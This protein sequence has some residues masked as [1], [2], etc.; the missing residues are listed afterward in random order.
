MTWTKVILAVALLAASASSSPL[1]HDK[2]GHFGSD[3]RV[4][5]DYRLPNNTAPISYVVRLTPYI[6]TGNFTF[7]GE[8]QILL[9][10][11]EPTSTIT[12]HTNQLT[13]NETLTTL[14]SAAGVSQNVT[15]HTYV[16]SE[17]FLV[18]GVENVLPVGNYTLNFTFTGI[19]SDDMA[20]FYRSSYT[21]ITGDTV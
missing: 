8:T 9:A 4:D 13:Y 14:V 12:V 10:V 20:G 11:L 6:F 7:D 17:H 15:S 16:E 5:G 21:S 1:L 2:L 19:L 3:S 18:I